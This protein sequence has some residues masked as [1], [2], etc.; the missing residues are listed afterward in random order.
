MFI[1]PP[2]AQNPEEM[3]LTLP[4]RTGSMK[5]RGGSGGGKGGEVLARKMNFSRSLGGNR[6]N[7][8]GPLLPVSLALSA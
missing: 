7:G 6:V 4:S 1:T 5:D 8:R 3:T 2:S